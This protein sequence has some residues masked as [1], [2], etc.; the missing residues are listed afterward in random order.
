MAGET[1]A[2]PHEQVSATA[3]VYD[4]PC[5]IKGFTTQHG[6]HE[7]TY[8]IY[9]A[10]NAGEAVRVGKM[11]S[12]QDDPAGN[13]RDVFPGGGF[14]FYRGMYVVVTTNGTGQ[15]LTPHEM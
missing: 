7:T 10:I 3:T 2:G 13:E 11:L 6:S 12:I 1:Q 8:D 5:N 14:K 15:V 4:Y 9:D